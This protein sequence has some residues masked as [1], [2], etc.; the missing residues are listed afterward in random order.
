MTGEWIYSLTL[1]TQSALASFIWMYFS[2]KV[3][4]GF[5]MVSV[6]VEVIWHIQN[7]FIG[8]LWG[9]YTSKEVTPCMDSVGT[10]CDL[11][12]V[13]YRSIQTL[14]R[15]LDLSQIKPTS[16][17]RCAV[18]VKCR[19]CCPWGAQHGGRQKAIGTDLSSSVQWGKGQWLV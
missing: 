12:H 18:G 3:E 6:K 16:T 7:L 13:Q 19:S 5:E 11:T 8:W 17:D 4:D 1:F 2:P 9:R 10:Q 14:D 15:R